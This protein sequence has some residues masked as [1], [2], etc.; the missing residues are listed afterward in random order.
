MFSN[1]YSTSA[2]TGNSYV[3]NRGAA[4]RYYYDDRYYAAAANNIP[5][6]GKTGPTVGDV[7][8][9]NRPINKAVRW[10]IKAE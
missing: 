3:A 7:G 8:D 5:T 6:L 4:Q 2:A 9:E 10:L 1:A